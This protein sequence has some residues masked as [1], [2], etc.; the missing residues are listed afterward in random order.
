MEKVIIRFNGRF[1]IEKEYWDKIGRIGRMSDKIYLEP[2]EV[3]YVLDKE[4]GIVKM[5]DKT[6]DK[7]EF[8]EEFKDKIDYKKYLVFREIRDLGYYADIFEDKVIVHERGNRNK[9][10]YL[11]YPVFENE[12]LSW[13]RILDLLEEAKRIGCKLLLGIIDFEYDIVFYEVN[14]KDI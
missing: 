11:V 2:E 7:E 14:E 4:W 5:D 9:P 1:W 10:I 12:K 8:L 6:L 13:R 3:L